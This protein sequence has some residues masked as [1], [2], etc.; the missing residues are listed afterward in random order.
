MFHNFF[1]PSDPFI[2]SMVLE[3]NLISDSMIGM[4]VIFRAS[5]QLQEGGLDGVRIRDSKSGTY[6]PDFFK[7]CREKP[8]FGC[9]FVLGHFVF[10]LQVAI[11]E[12]P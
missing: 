11:G 10:F 6:L 2:P 4:C 9:F 12:S 1:I 7:K 5:L 3:D 8:T